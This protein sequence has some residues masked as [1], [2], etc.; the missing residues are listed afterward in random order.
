M[1]GSRP[2]GSTAPNRTSASA[3]PYS[4]PPKYAERGARH[5]VAPGQQHGEPGVD[6]DD[7]AEYRWP[8]P[9]DQVVLPT[10]QREAAAVDALGLDL[11]VG[12]HHHD[13]QIRV[14]RGSYRLVD[15]PLRIGDIWLD[16]DRDA[17]D[18]L[19]PCSRLG[20]QVVLDPHVDRP[21]AVDGHRGRDRGR[22]EDRGAEVHALRFGHVLATQFPVDE[23]PAAADCRVA[24]QDLAAGLGS[25]GQ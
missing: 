5:L 24:E 9:R 21:P 18:P 10:G 3:S 1:V 2:P 22:R 7:R 16:A 14:A 15:Q 19:E 23:H 12:A 13:G 11:R 8:P 20:S 25:P 17:E 4:W 6:H